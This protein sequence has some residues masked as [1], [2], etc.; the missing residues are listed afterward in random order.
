LLQF[1]V[2]AIVINNSLVGIVT[3][4]FLKNLNSI[5]KA[6]ASALEL[7]FTAIFSFILLGIPIYW[8]T[9]LAVCIV[10]YSVV[11][12]AKNPMKTNESDLKY[13]LESQSRK[14]KANQKLDR[15]Q[16]ELEEKIIYNVW[17]IIRNKKPI[18]DKL[19]IV[20]RYWKTHF[21]S[22]VAFYLSSLRL[23]RIE[24]WR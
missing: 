2:I 5:L 6:F 15:I 13:Q 10:S 12:Y 23:V 16:E 1:F 21:L 8:N 7:I 22:S 9:I 19:S 17:N 3:S 14:T 20:N 24:N 11:L 18:F 4:L